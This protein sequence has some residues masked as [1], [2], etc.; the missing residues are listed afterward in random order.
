MTFGK[1]LRAARLH[2][3]LTQDQLGDLA[4]CGQGV[5]SKIE[6][7]DQD[8]STYTVMF[9]RICGVSPDWLYDGTG[10]MII[11]KRIDQYTKPI[12]HMVE[13]AENMDAQDQ[14]RAA[15]LVDTLAEPMK[16]EAQQ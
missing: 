9:A 16:K 6:R 15:L 8:T 5:I 13:V 2:A 14:Y 10:P 1:R 7:G 3:K 4:E 11:T 12:Q